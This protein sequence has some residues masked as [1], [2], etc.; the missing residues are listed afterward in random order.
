[1]TV[2]SAPLPRPA[3]VP[4]WAMPLAV[5]GLIYWRVK[6]H[7]DP[8]GSWIVFGPDG[9]ALARRIYAIPQ[10]RRRPNDGERYS[11]T[12]WALAPAGLYADQQP[13]VVW[14]DPVKAVAALVQRL[15][16][17]P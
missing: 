1:M 12:G 10:I 4:G 15:R 8:A 3:G 6:D 13:A 11:V 2:L 16:Q 14:E 5:H 17:L 7:A 9:I